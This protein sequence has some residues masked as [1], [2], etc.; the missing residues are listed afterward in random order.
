M[1]LVERPA[2]QEVLAEGLT[3]RCGVQARP[4]R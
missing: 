3:V 2:L 1:L 4:Q